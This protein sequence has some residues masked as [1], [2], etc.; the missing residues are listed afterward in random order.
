MKSVLNWKEVARTY[1]T[2]LLVATKNCIG[3]RSLMNNLVP[4][5][6]RFHDFVLNNLSVNSYNTFIATIRDTKWNMQKWRG[7]TLMKD[8]MSLTILQQM[9]QNERFKTIIEIGTYE[10]GSALWMEDINKA[11]GNQCRIHTIDINAEQVK[12]PEDSSV[13]FQQLDTH[14]IESYELPHIERPLLVIE[15]AHKNV[16]GVL[17]H[18]DTVL[19]D[20][21]YLIV[22]DTIDNLKHQIVAEFIEGKPYLVDATY[23]DMWGY[24]NSYNLNSILKKVIPS[25]SSSSGSN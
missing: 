22:E 17:S 3:R 1:A 11:I 8:P 20:G 10:G 12:L 16:S 25:T 23:C 24:N 21:D 19:K 13:V 15:D 6:D 2:S 14:N 5:S 9:L 18:F 7:L 4:F